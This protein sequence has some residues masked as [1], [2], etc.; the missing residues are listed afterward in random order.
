[1][2]GGLIAGLR[3]ILPCTAAMMLH[4]AFCVRL[5]L[6]PIA[7]AL[8]LGVNAIANLSGQSPLSLDRWAV[9]I[10]SFIAIFA[11]GLPMPVVFAVAA[12][13]GAAI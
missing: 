3:L 4:A 13:Y 1:M 7:Y 11:F 8:F 12:V 5:G 10:L 9:A 6:L 2:A